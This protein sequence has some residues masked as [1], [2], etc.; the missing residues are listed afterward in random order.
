MPA[1]WLARALVCALCV[2]APGESC[3]TIAMTIGATYDLSR[4]GVSP[5][6]YG[7]IG[8]IFNYQMMYGTVI[9]FSNYTYQRYYERASF[10]SKMVVLFANVIWI[11]FPMWWMKVCFEIVKDGG[12]FRGTS[13]R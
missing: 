10:G 4:F 9:Y 11:V 7:L 1:R 2:R 5:L 3:A 13:L 8:L 6:A 12:S